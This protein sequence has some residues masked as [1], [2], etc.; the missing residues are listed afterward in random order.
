MMKFTLASV[1]NRV[2]LLFNTYTEDFYYTLKDSIKEVR[3]FK[4]D[5]KVVDVKLTRTA[6]QYELE[7][8]DEKLT[9]NYVTNTQ[10]D[11][12]KHEVKQ[13]V[14]QEQFDSF[15]QKIYHLQEKLDDY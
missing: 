13:K 6:M 8:V 1:K 3:N 2:D 9:K 15:A 4:S 5:L 11:D 10:F 12:L 14:E 7:Q